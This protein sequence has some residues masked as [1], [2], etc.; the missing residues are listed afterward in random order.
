MNPKYLNL[1]GKGKGQMINKLSFLIFLSAFIAV[2]SLAMVIFQ[3]KIA[4]P[5]LW[6]HLKT[7]EFI[8]QKM[9]V[10][11]LDIFSFTKETQAWVDHEWL[12]QGVCFLIFKN[13]S[14]D[15]LVFFKNLIFTSTLLILLL[16]VY[17]RLR[18]FFALGLLFLFIGT[19]LN[20]PTLRP[21]LFSLFFLAIFLSILYKKRESR[22]LFILP[23]LEILWVNI[24]GYFFLG[25]LVLGIFWVQEFIS[26]RSLR[27][28]AF[29]KLG[30][31]FFLCIFACLLNPYFLRGALY[32]FFIL[33]DM[34][35]GKSKEAFESIIELQSPFKTKY[36][37]VKFYKAAI[38]IS[39]L[40][41]FFAP[42]EKNL[43]NLWEHKKNSKFG[44]IL[45]SIFNFI[46]GLKK[47]VS[48][49][50]ILLWI[51]FLIFSAR[52][53]RNVHFFG[54]ISVYIT[55][56][57]LKGIFQRLY[58]N[59]KPVKLLLL[60]V[61]FAAVLC[62]FTWR[63]A[64][65]RLLGISY[66]LQDN[67]LKPSSYLWGREEVIYPYKEADFLNN[68][69]PTMRFFNDFNSGAFLTFNGSPGF[70]VFIDGRTEFYGRDFLKDYGE[71]IKGN[72]D[73]FNKLVSKYNLR[74]FFIS[75]RHLEPKEKLIELLYRKG[76]KVVFFGDAAIIF[77]RDTQANKEY[78]NKHMIDLDN[79]EAEQDDLLELK[80]KKVIPY[81]HINRLRILDILKL[82]QPSIKEAKAV[83]RLSPHEF[84]AYK[85]LGEVELRKEK[86]LESYEYL[87]KAFTLGLRSEDLFQLLA[88]TYIGLAREK[89]ARE[90]LTLGL[91]Y[92]PKS[93][94]I[95][96][97]L[98]E[99]TKDQPLEELN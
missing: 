90:I 22:F 28:T 61:C 84:F 60:N 2:F 29:S 34:L 95:K 85:V 63:V 36:I 45:K 81:S 4:D 98:D 93:R 48:I 5:D 89:D 3:M 83:L 94:S 77:L 23:F 14:F 65:P 27:D 88:K 92:H 55:L 72:E 59:V 46:R 32:P 40:S 44:C 42:L 53:V 87:Y 71:V 10:P 7:G 11:K 15:G 21:D 74:G 50:N 38:I 62:F 70:K 78:L 99:L 1:F 56:D 20:R 19:S 76:W 8:T 41:F 79:W 57:N 80:L 18:S 47:R 6:L 97:L 86:Y 49:R 52:A 68:F 33:K 51:I 13:F 82:D 43:H 17:D 9:V 54:A 31:V 75:Y 69:K 67:Q 37:S 30:L 24:H 26:N 39:F 25:P 91:K 12:F 73:I 64:K 35:V 58:D 16:G 66:I 96:K